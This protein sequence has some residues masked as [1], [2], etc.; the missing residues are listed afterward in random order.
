MYQITPQRGRPAFLPTLAALL[1][2][3]SLLLAPT[4]KLLAA[5]PP[6]GF[7]SL[8]GDLSSVD[9]WVA[10]DVD[11]DRYMLEDDE[12]AAAGF[13]K[14]LRFAAPIETALSPSLFGTWEALED[15]SRLWR[16]RILS[17]GAYS[18]NLGI[19]PMELPDGATLHL[20]P[21]DR[22]RFAGPYVSSDAVDG[23]GFWSPVIPGE[24]IVAE[25]RIPAEAQGNPD[26]VI[27]QVSHD[28]RDFLQILEGN[29][30]QGWCNID[31]ICPQADPW[32]AEIRSVGVYTRQGTWTCS[33]QLVN[34]HTETK[35]PYFLT[36]RHCG[37]NSSNAG[38][39]RVYWNYESPVCGQ[40]S[41]GS[42]GQSQLG[43]T[44]RASWA[45]SDFCLLQLN[46]EPNEAFNVYYAGWDA[47]ETHSPQQCTAIHHPNCDEK[48]ISFNYDPLTVTSYLG[49]SVPGDGSHWRVDAWE[50]GTTEPGSSGSGIWDENKRLVGQLHGG[51]AS[52]SSIT[53]DWYGR[54]SRSW[55]GGGSSSSQLSY[56]LDP[57]GTG[58][59]L[60]DG[61]DPFD[62]ASVDEPARAAGGP[63][64][65]FLKPNPAVGGFQVQLS[66]DSSAA[67]GI[68]IF[69]AAGR[70]VAHHPAR[71]M[72]AG[73]SSFGL[74]PVDASGSRLAPGLYFVRVAFDGRET[75]AQKL[76]L[77]E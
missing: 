31:V 5:E 49:Y 23:E 26:F 45:T 55:S 32:R 18:I 36:A 69:D 37:I 65:A 28:Y 12:R 27:T 42:L 25:L 72:P 56:W 59:R 11:V 24:E 3:S 47:R 60:L 67:V 44:F 1:A 38:T 64:M 39:V 66:L 21:A 17:G 68:E 13:E 70:R 4:T 62:T 35:P 9:L 48:A 7:G 54:L 46:Q 75:A 53:S 29:L 77:V 74:E 8:A 51:Y 15:G 20:Y 41:G 58:E 19:D 22:S 2:F 16:L 63:A 73:D 33:G 34:S 14:A 6:A 52:C 43:S 76:I 71:M 10:P 50:V 40:L 61:Y 30:R 57:D